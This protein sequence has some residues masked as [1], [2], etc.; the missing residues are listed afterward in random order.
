ME[1]ISRILCFLNKWVPLITQRI[2]PMPVLLLSV[3]IMAFPADDEYSKLIASG[4]SHGKTGDFEA[5][6][7]DYTS[8]IA[9]DPDKVNGYYYRGT[10]KI[11]TGDFKSAILD[12]TKSIELKPDYA[13][14]YLNRGYSKSCRKD[15]VGAIQDYNKAIELKPDY[16]VAFADRGHSKSIIGDRDG[17]IQ[18]YSKAIKLKPDY[19]EAYEYRSRVE[20]EKRDK[21]SAFLDLNKSIEINPKFVLAYHDRGYIKSYHGDQDGS[22]VDFNKA[23]ELKPNLA[24]A[25]LCR[26]NS[27]SII[28]D[29]DGAFSD[30]NKAIELQPKSSHGYL[31]RSKVKNRNKDF[32]CALLDANKAIEL[33]PNNPYVYFRLGLTHYDSGKYE[34]SLDDFMKC[35][36]YEESNHLF[37]DYSW[38]R[39]WLNRDR[40][41]GENA[42]IQEL[43]D[44]KTKGKI[45]LS[46]K[47]QV[48]IFRYLSNQIDEQSLITTAKNNDPMTEKENLC[49][50]Y[51]YSGTRLLISGKTPDAIEHFKK[52]VSTGIIYYEE[53]DSAQAELSHMSAPAK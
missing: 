12:F 8:A 22:I 45:S 10:A 13:D 49:E 6:I 33:D 48:A 4:F 25:Y 44:S 9:I 36:V 28:G 29:R 53:Y 40:L 24:V 11:K 20:Y 39:T 3:Q 31:M 21:E 35:K 15:Q 23:I 16:A 2:M 32:E 37:S 51:F 30:I 5:A 17:A 50:A 14:A 1:T 26:G 7:A 19:A 41:S 43:L 47:W 27:K 18:D 46:S 38:F 52:C 42:A 34:E